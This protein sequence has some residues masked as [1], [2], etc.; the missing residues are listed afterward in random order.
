LDPKI[1]KTGIRIWDKHIGSA[2]LANIKI[3]NKVARHVWLSVCLLV[4]I[5]VPTVLAH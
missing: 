2:I 5:P 4:S 1:G 3:I